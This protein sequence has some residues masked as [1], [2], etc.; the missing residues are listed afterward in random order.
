MTYNI[1]DE[2]SFEELEF[3]RKK[4]EEE[5]PDCKMYLVGCKGD[6]EQKVPFSEIEE[7]FS[8]L[9][10]FITSAKLGEGV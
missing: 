7:K 6:L 1:N 5:V 3:Y 4:V 10:H 2:K 8:G 9:P